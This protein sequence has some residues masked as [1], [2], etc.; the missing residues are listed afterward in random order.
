MADQARWFKLWCSAPSD[1]DIQNLCP[2]DRWAW[3]AFGAYTKL[4]GTSG[5]VKVS[6]TNGALAA[7][8]GVTVRELLPCIKRLPHMTVETCENSNGSQGVTVFVSWHNWHK[9]QVD[10]SSQRVAK[11][12][13]RVTPKKRRE[14]KRREVPPKPPGDFAMIDSKEAK[15]FVSELTRNL[16][17]K[18]RP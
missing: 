8:M 6:A 15:Q 2:A 9:Y 12:R 13:A 11:Y 1:D 4:H 7:E 10:D 18:M 5:E 3:V 17:A 14:E 16:S